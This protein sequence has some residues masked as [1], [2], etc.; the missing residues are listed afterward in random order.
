[1]FNRIWKKFMAALLLVAFLPIGYFG[2]Q[3][4]KAARAAVQ[5]E[6]LK[7]ILLNAIT[8]SKEIERVF[9]NAHAD[10][11]YLRSSLALE[12][13]LDVPR[14]KPQAAIYWKSLVEREF[15]L[16]LSIKGGYSEAGLLDEYGN[17]SVVVR[18]AGDKLAALEDDQ[19]RN[20]LT[21]PYYVQA[22]QLED[23]AVAAI[24]MRSSMDPSRSLEDVT[25]VRYATK[26]F[27]RMGK[28]RGVIYIDLN[29]SEIM[30]ALGHTSFERRREAA[31]VTHEGKYIYDP[32]GENPPAAPSHVPALG[33]GPLD[34]APESVMAQILSGRHGVISDAP[35]YLYAF[36]SIYP[37]IGNRDFYY[38]VFD[39]YP[40]SDFA[41]KIEKIWWMY[42][43]GALGA[44]ALTAVAAMAVSRALTR[45]IS[46]LRRGAEALATNRLGH[47]ID[48][49]S[50]DEL[51]SLAKAFNDM[52]EAVQEYQDSLEKKVEERTRQIKQ[53]ERRLMQSEKLAAIGFLSAGVAHEVN[54]PISIIVTRL[55]L[56]E[57]DIAKGNTE[58]VKKDLETLKG[59]AVRI[60]RIAANLLTFSREPSGEPVPMD[61]GESVRRVV[62]LIEHPI[63]KKGVGLRVEIDPALPAVLGSPVGMEQVVYNIVTNAYQATEPGGEIVIRAAADGRGAVRLTISDTGHGIPEEVR[64]RLFEP[65][66]T[67]KEAGQGTGL[68]L[69]I[70]YG[71][72]R[73][74]GGS[75]E[76]ESDPGAGSVFTITLRESAAPRAEEKAWTAKTKA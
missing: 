14:E 42:I 74:F 67:T 68:G 16:F 8:R 17:E 39:R 9:I 26:V 62:S 23:L 25:L 3:D 72:V 71:L 66:F 5:D 13:L 61:L 28:P 76:V 24:P 44:L 15:M 73:G 32:Y 35:K 60:G 21:A 2:Y 49:K 34:D 45:N 11:N 37:Q 48:I 33:A 51:E 50:G 58:R 57:K 69:S 31:L 65:F 7:T 75:I 1:M 6:A 12:L 10:I 56:M 47:R 41:P 29:G 18:K 59:H 52:A 27:D 38:V 64:A 46:R 53:V 55:E 4:L 22:A 30:T 54:N 36:S 43:I 40:R 63:R 19:K 70:S 20:R